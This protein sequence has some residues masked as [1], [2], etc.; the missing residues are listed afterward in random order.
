MAIGRP[1]TNSFAIVEPHAKLP[2]STVIVGSSK[3]AARASS[4]FFGPA[5]LPDLSPYSPSRIPIDVDNLPMGYDLGTGGFDLLAPYKSGYHFTVGS[6]YTVTAFGTL[7]DAQGEP[8][9]L[10]T[11]IA[12]EEGHPDDHRVTVFTNKVGRFGAQGLRPGRWVIE[13]ATEPVTRF[14][15]DVPEDTVGLLRLDTLAPVKNGT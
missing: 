10:L 15:F 8:I 7:T 11:G 12:F 13:M 9:P 4:D 5:L 1:V 14:V 6:D 3:D 2:D